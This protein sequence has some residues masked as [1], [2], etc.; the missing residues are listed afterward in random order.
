M[1]A[2]AIYTNMNE[3][4]KVAVQIYSANKSPTVSR[5]LANLRKKTEIY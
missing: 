4:H 2:L 5:R 3:A 1:H